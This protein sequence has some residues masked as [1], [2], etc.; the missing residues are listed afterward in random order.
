MSC[1]CRWGSHFYGVGQMR[2]KFE[3]IKGVPK[4]IAEVS[5]GYFHS[6]I[7]LTDGTLLGCGN[8]GSGQLG[9]GNLGII[10]EWEEI[11]GVPKNIKKV[12]CKGDYSI[13]MSTDGTLMACGDTGRFGFGDRMR[14]KSVFVEIPGVPKNILDVVCGDSIIILLNDGTLMGCGINQYG[15]CGFKDSTARNIFEV[16]PDI[17][18]NVAKV[19]CGLHHTMILLS[20]GTLMSCGGNQYGQLGLGDTRHRNSFEVI[21]NIPKNIAQIITSAHSTFIKLTDGTLMSCGY[22]ESGQ[23]GCGDF[24]IRNVFKEI[25][26]LKKNIA[27]VV[28]DFNHTVIRFT[29]GILMSC[30]YNNYGALGLEEKHSR[31]IFE[32]IKGIPKIV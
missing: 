23:L 12:M 25:T 18:K 5:N 21:K 11:K 10:N 17:P 8:N 16:I 30:G 13:I 29:D 19:V 24:S 9:L 31:N 32:E 26:G 4:N 1:G 27:E 20:D 3:E 22:N 14:P 6:I 28:C 2:N 7:R 15:Q